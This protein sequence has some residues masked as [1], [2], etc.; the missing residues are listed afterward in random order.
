MVTL[1]H[2]IGFLICLPIF[3]NQCERQFVIDKMLDQM[4]YLIRWASK[5]HF[6]KYTHCKWNH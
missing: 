6:I 2:R 4:L 1:E 3:V 5:K